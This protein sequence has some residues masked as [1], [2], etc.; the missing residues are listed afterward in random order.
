MEGSMMV[1]Q[2]QGQRMVCAQTSFQH[3]LLLVSHKLSQRVFQRD[4]V[5]GHGGDGLG[6]GILEFFSGLNGSMSANRRMR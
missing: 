1:T 5:S 2:E 3:D 4:M 6:L